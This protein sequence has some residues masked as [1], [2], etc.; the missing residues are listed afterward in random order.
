MLSSFQ[1]IHI[2]RIFCGFDNVIRTV[3]TS[4]GKNQA[5]NGRS[6]LSAPSFNPSSLPYSLPL[7]IPSSL[8]SYLPSRVEAEMS[9]S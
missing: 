9:R 8:P 5:A 3:G 4:K 7:A 1:Q 6:L 2:C